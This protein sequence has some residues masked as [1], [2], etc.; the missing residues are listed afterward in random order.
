[1]SVIE[2]AASWTVP[3]G[4]RPLNNSVMNRVSAVFG[5]QENGV[6]IIIIASGIAAV[7]GHIAVSVGFNSTTAQAGIWDYTAVNSA[8]IPLS[9][10][11]IDMAPLGFNF[12]QALERSAIAGATMVSNQ[13]PVSLSGLTFQARM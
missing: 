12:W 9:A 4:I 6:S 8:A 11:Y 1:M 3:A 10:A 7:G 5:L 13:V 2:P